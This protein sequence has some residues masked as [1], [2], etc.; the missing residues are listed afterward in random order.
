MNLFTKA[1]N[2]FFEYRIWEKIDLVTIVDAKEKLQ[3]C[4]K[5]TPIAIMLAL[6]KKASLLLYAQEPTSRAVNEGTQLTLS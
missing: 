4:N 5:A 3:Q 6:D 1:F 2:G